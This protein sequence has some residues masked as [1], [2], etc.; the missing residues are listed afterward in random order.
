M[1]LTRTNGRRDNQRRGG[2]RSVPAYALLLL[3]LVSLVTFASAADYNT[4]P[5]SAELKALAQ[6]IEVDE[7]TYGCG[8]LTTPGKTYYV[9]IDGNDQADGLSRGRAWRH[10]AHGIAQLHAGDTLIISEGEYLETALVMD[11]KKGPTGK[12]GSPITIMAAPR[13][14]VI[15]SCA[16]KPA[17]TRTPSTQF[18]WQGKAVMGRGQ[19]CAWETDTRIMLQRVAT[20]SMV[21]ELP[22][23]WCWDKDSK[24]VYV[25]FSDSRGANVHELAVRSGKT[26]ASV[27]GNDACALAIGVSY[28][29]LK[30]LR[31]EFDNAGVLVRGNRVSGTGDDAV[32]SGG[33]HITIEDCAFSSTWFAGLVLKQG[34]QRILVKT[35]YGVLNGGRGTFLLNDAGARHV[36]F[37]GNRTDPSPQTI[38]TLGW[39]HHYGIGTYG[40]EGR[41]Y[42]LINNILNGRLSFRTKFMC[43][44]TVLQGNIL[45]G[46]CGFVPCTYYTLKYA[47]EDRIMV[48]NNVLLKNI[49]LY[50]RPKPDS[51]AAGDW[52]G[53]DTA[54]VN[55][56]V[57]SGAPKGVSVADARFADPTYLDYRLQSDSP[58]RGKAIGGG[59]VG[60][61][62]GAFGRVF[63]V[64]TAGDDENAGTTNQAPMATLA[65]ATSGLK[66]G[67]T[68]YLMP[69]AY[70]EPLVIAA[71]GT[72]AEPIRVR[73][74][75]RKAATLPGARIAGNWIELEGISVAGKGENGII[76]TGQNTTLRSC[77]VRDAS[78][79]GIQL[80]GATAPSVLSCTIVHN[81]TGIHLGKGT[82]DVTVRDC[83][84]A[85]NASRAVTFANGAQQGYL[86]SNNLYSGDGLD[87]DRIGR[88]R[89]STV[90]NPGF[91]DTA[92]NDFRLAW[93]SPAAHLGPFGRP[94]GSFEAAIRAP[95]IEDATVSSISATSA[96][97]TWRTPQDDSTGT[98]NW[99]GKGDKTWRKTASSPQGTVHG[100]GL[101]G[102]VPSTDYVVQVRANGRRGGSTLSDVV[103]FKTTDA[104]QKPTTYYVAASGNDDA[105]GKTEATPWA[106]IR[107]ASF[108]VKPGDTVIVAPGTYYHA[109]APLHGGTEDKRITF[110]T[111]GD[112]LVLIDG[113]QVTAPLVNI[114][115][116]SFITVDGFTFDNLPTAGH[117]GVMRI[118]KS[119]GV[120]VLR[121][122][123]GYAR[124]HG[125]FGNGINITGCKGGRI[126]GNVIWGTRY[127]VTA[128]DCTDIL[129]KNNTF[130]RGQVFSAYF[131]GRTHK[132]CRFVNNIFW[133]PTSVPNAALVITHPEERLEMTSDYNFWGEMVAKTQVAYLYST[134]ILKL[135]LTGHDLAEWRTNSGQDKHSLQA[136][137]LFIAPQAGDFRLKP[138]SPAIGAGENGETMG[139]CSA[140]L[141]S[142]KGDTS[143]KAGKGRTIRLKAA[144]SGSN[145]AKTRFSWSLPEGKTAEGPTLEYAAPPGT[146][147]FVLKVT[148]TAPDG[149]TYSTE[150]RISLLPVE[151]A[152]NAGGIYIEGEDFI[153]H[154]GG[155][156][157]KFYQPLNASGNRAFHYWI[158][159]V[160]NWLEWEFSAAKAGQ[161]TVM[162]RYTTNF[163]NARRKF[164]IDGEVPG[165]EY[166]NIF[167][168]TTNG[169]AVQDDTWT[170][171]KLTPP[172]ELTP[173][174]HRIRMT[175][176]GDAINIDFIAIVPVE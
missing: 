138:E 164:E 63:Y 94:A 131:C 65:K 5:D 68:L 156:E 41:D 80:S 26:T 24:T 161:H 86:A 83:I 57:P 159:P 43:R 56:Y 20:S 175:N 4:D 155:G 9:S 163:K 141:I 15:I 76:V 105:D 99:K 165:P 66:A 171:R 102:L 154:G 8:P 85:D 51:G 36:L 136:D 27:F 101:K 50:G 104:P 60:V 96:S 89:R 16:Q 78:G 73:A 88:E 1:M 113:A 125:G 30:G 33:D 173:G 132:G 25:H 168:P 128:R 123:I 146:D 106:T 32:Y 81:A 97:V 71:V 6:P 55:N 91:V 110:R 150:E 152:G 38:R 82:R 31:F 37:L 70:T 127:H 134:N 122:R 7:S 35:C 13:H 174:K 61:H 39:G 117:P 87:K 121:C 118:I 95:V 172:L 157:I 108:G 92:E 126:E 145:P 151:L 69:G 72:E 142:I 135:A 46:S 137:P 74:H 169:F 67:D 40:K 2:W 64:S 75:G 48:R 23:T 10:V 44:A 149:R 129:I 115:A 49:G 84:L 107:R 167:F 3:P 14:R 18:T 139:A 133:F 166:E 12:P 120:E 59:N 45:T 58:L 170:F 42:L 116:K 119:H 53:S 144:L 176:L 19:G 34:A 93:D 77:V 54:F 109:I 130:T 28:V 103:S 147:R 52:A 29:R 98:V 143:L 17:L 62:R 124:A 112:G 47:P 11:A 158:R 22:G 153:E 100:S 148:A 140:S 162:I 111:R 79:T 114:S 90:A 160:G 21:D